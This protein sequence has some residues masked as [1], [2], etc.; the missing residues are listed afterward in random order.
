MRCFGGGGILNGLEFNFKQEHRLYIYVKTY[1]K[2]TWLEK[3][4]LQSEVGTWFHSLY[5]RYLEV[6]GNP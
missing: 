2:K 5:I 4:V 3:V 6:C 1:R